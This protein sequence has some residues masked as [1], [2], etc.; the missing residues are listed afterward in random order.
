MNAN[1][2]RRRGFSLVEILII[3]AV[4]GVVSTVAI[5]LMTDV[6]DAAKKEKLEQDVVVVNNGKAVI[7]G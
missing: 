5:P 7:H 6:P 2:P 1:H 4:I 3:V